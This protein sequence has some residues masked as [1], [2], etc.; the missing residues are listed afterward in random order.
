MTGGK[1]EPIVS[2]QLHDETLKFYITICR[3]KFGIGWVVGDI[4]DAWF[5]AV[6]RERS[7]KHERAIC[8]SIW[9]LRFGFK[10]L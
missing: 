7:W 2:L 5:F 4:L 9:R 3:V 1:T 10:I 8:V 6:N